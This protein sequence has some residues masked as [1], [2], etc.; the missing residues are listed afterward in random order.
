MIYAVRIKNRDGELGMYF[1]NID[2]MFERINDLP[3][4]YHLVEG[5]IG[6]TVPETVKE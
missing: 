6:Y 1:D 5:Y 3:P 2:Q 4:G